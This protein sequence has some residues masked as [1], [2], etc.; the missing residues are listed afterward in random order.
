MRFREQSVVFIKMFRPEITDTKARREVAV[1]RR[2]L[3]LNLGDHPNV[4]NLKE[5]TYG[6]VSRGAQSFGYVMIQVQ[7]FCAQGD[8][9]SFVTGELNGKRCMPEGMARA[10]F[11][12]IASGVHF[13]HKR[14]MYHRDLKMENIMVSDWTKLK[15]A[16]FGTGT[17]LSRSKTTHV[18][19]PAVN[20]DDAKGVAEAVQSSG[21]RSGGYSTAAWDMFQC[22]ALLFMMVCTDHLVA[23]EVGGA[24]MWG[25]LQ[26]IWQNQRR[27]FGALG[28]KTLQTF[29]EQC[30]ASRD[31]A[32]GQPLNTAFWKYWSCQELGPV[33][34]S[35][36]LRHLLNGMLDCDPQKRITFEQVFAHTWMQ[37][38]GT[39]EEDLRVAMRAKKAD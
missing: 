12:Q 28:D 19:T 30:E 14:G 6:T 23:K 39:R 36:D 15:I 34:I 25:Q 38:P 7:E 35:E 21:A 24:S 13:M 8:L 5:V 10:L 16:D 18:G 26:M 27:L 9:F 22:G 32:T 11:R 29:R 37:A 33:A 4:V 2:F 3:D 31:Q 20:P 17:D 1:L